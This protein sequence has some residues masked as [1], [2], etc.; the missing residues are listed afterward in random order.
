MSQF[1]SSLLHH[2]RHPKRTVAVIAVV[3]TGLITLVL[4]GASVVPFSSETAQAKVIAVLAD[5]F[6]AD[7][8]VR[9]L[10]FKV[11]P[12]VRAEG[13]GL[14]IRHRGRRDVPPLISIDRFWVEGNV[15]GLLRKH[16]SLVTVEGL[17]IEIPADRNRGKEFP[18]R[19]PDRDGSQ[20]FVIDEL[21]STDGR[22]VILPRDQ[23]RKPKVW[24]IHDLRMQ[25]V[26]FDRPMPFEAT[27]TNAIPP[28]EIATKGTFGPWQSE[29]PGRTP[30]KGTFTFAR[31]DLGVF[32]GIAGI[33]SAHGS[34]GGTLARID[35]HGETE[36]PEFT[37]KG[38]HSVPLRTRYHAIVDGTN[39]D[40]L[41]ERIDASFLDT[42]LVAK[43][44]VVHT[45]GSEGRTVTLDVT[46]DKARL[47]DVLRLAVK[48]PQAP[49]TGALSLKTTLRLPPGDTDVV[50]K[51][52]LDG[53]FAIDQTR[54]TDVDVQSKINELSHRSRGNTPQQQTER[55][56][57]QFEG[58]FTLAGG[59]VTIPAV[60]FDMRGS[61]VRLTGT[62]DLI[63]ETLDF[64]GTL[65]MDVKVSQTTTGFKS[66]LLK[67]AD[68]LFS[69]EVGGSA[70]PI[71]IT[72]N[73]EAPKFGLDTG[74]VLSE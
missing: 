10:R 68:P 66:L 4:V 64:A 1:W 26:A 48:S 30:L 47:E 23:N 11:L 51:L 62:Y 31:A 50:Q 25:S 34:F 19:A 52:Q 60:T 8:E 69:R 35:I 70:I 40:T 28:G 15:V 7:V 13:A 12:W 37:V 67:I 42:A 18:G 59:T 27:L 71:K 5:R 57:S 39:G 14:V 54:F 41:L 24:G 6:D 72:G 55:V 17:D 29:Q 49:M 73:R 33:L 20:I 65:F 9:E 22:L 53:R 32:K 38:G 44:G 56:A 58:T 61:I 63:P 43:G 16:V 74:R 36:T 21:R 2:R 45:L 3:A 46:M